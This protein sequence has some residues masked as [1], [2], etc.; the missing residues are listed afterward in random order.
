MKYDDILQRIRQQKNIS[1]EDIEGKVK[2]KLQTLGDIISKEGAAHIVANELGVKLF[3]DLRNKKLKIHDMV[4]GMRAVTIAGKITRLGNV[5]SYNKNGKSGKVANLTFADETGKM[6]AVLWDTKHISLIEENKL[7]EGDTIKITKGNIKENNGFNEIHLANFSELI[8]NP[9]DITITAITERQHT[10]YQDKK[11]NELQAP[12]DNIAITGTIVQAF[13]PRFY[14][15][16]PQCTKKV[17]PEGNN[18]RCPEHGVVTPE[19]LPI[20]NIFFDD[21]T[22]SIRV[23]AFKNNVELLLGQNKETILTYQTQPATF[24]TVKQQLLGKQYKI[25]GK[26]HHNDT[27][28]R[29]EFTSRIILDINPEREARTLLEK[30]PA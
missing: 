4:A 27:T 5:I 8:I 25:I 22:D 3:D 12:E 1:L 9:A 15:G 6:R 17:I 21:G 29:N 13:E 26:V 30:V 24:E 7:H 23:T 28:G 2:T 11:I 20:L 19:A 16:C 18:M 14:Q 10:A